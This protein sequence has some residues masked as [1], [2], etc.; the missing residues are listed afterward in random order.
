MAKIT[1]PLMSASAA[2][3]WG[4]GALQFRRGLQATHAYRPA[5][6]G[7]VNQGP[8]S[9]NQ[10]RIRQTYRGARADWT[11]LSAPERTAW[12]TQ[13]R[14]LGLSGWNLYAQTVLTAASATQ[15]LNIAVLIGNPP[16]TTDLAA[17]PS[18]RIVTR[19]LDFRRFLP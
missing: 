16:L 15:T 19:R 13:A 11:A 17:D 5:P 2:G 10:A 7:T 6:P 12:N 8:A 4:K 3:N 14:P 9:P 18:R 1:G